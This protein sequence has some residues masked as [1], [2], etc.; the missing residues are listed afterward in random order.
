MPRGKVIFFNKKS[1]F[2]FIKDFNDNKDYYVRE[3]NLIDQVKQ[4]DEVEF[5]I[6]ESKKGFE[7]FA[8][9]KII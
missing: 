4:D 8:V 1:K 6:K 9:K 5:E 7:A 2:G 3:K